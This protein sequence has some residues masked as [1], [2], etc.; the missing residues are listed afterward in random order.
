MI[1]VPLFKDFQFSEIF[2][3]QIWHNWDKPPV[4]KEDK[5]T[6]YTILSMNTVNSI[7]PRRS[8]KPRRFF[9]MDSFSRQ[10]YQTKILKL[11]L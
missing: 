11:C 3:F 10:S 1:S 7:I 2:R 9:S 5:Q 8:V 4:F 6:V